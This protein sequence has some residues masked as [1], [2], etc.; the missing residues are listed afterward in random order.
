MKRAG[1]ALTAGWV[2]LVA[3]AAALAQNGGAVTPAPVPMRVAH[4][5]VVVVGNLGKLESKTVSAALLH[6]ATPHAGPMPKFDFHVLELKVEEE[7]RGAKK[8]DVIRFGFAPP[9]PRPDGPGPEP[10]KSNGA[11]YATGQE[12]LFFLTRHHHES[13]Q[14]CW[15]SWD[16][17]IDKKADNYARDLKLARR[18]AKLWEDPMA[19]LK[20]KDAE[21]RLLSAGML[22]YR[23]R[24]Y[25]PGRFGPETEA[26][27]ADESRRILNILAD[28]DWPTKVAPAS[29][30]PYEMTAGWLFTQLDV[31]FKDGW[32]SPDGGFDALF[33]AGKQWVKTHA[34]TYRIKRFVPFA[35]AKPDPRDKK[36][37]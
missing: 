15:P 28:A 16:S 32:L 31:S 33:A 5:D 30:I 26:I 14:V 4:A 20:A 35:A 29:S 36:K 34:N 12:C 9:R 3:G 19:G 7:L 2:L 22:I 8:G 13:F 17:C 37:Q 1:I 11:P 6:P 25:E 18:C 10:G 23:Y 24:H 21:D 27:P